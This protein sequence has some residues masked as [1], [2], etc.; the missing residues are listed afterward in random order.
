ML[1]SLARRLSLLAR[2]A[3]AGQGTS[4]EAFSSPGEPLY[5]TRHASGWASPKS[6]VIELPGAA[7]ADLF[8]DTQPAYRWPE[9]DEER[10]P[11]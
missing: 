8:P 5:G 3:A 4:A 11:A 7:A 10:E 6:P 2:P 9:R 1:A